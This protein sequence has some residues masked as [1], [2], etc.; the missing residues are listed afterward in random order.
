MSAIPIDLHIELSS[1]KDFIN[2]QIYSGNPYS[3]DGKELYE[4]LKRV[5]IDSELKPFLTSPK[6]ESEVNYYEKYRRQSQEKFDKFIPD[7]F[8]HEGEF[9][10]L[11]RIQYVYKEFTR[12]RDFEKL[13]LIKLLELKTNEYPI[14]EFLYFQQADNFYGQKESID[15]FLYQL[16]EKDSNC[17]LLQ[18]TCQVLI[19]WIG[20]QHLA[21]LKESAIENDNSE[22]DDNIENNNPGPD[23]TS[24]EKI[25]TQE[26]WNNEIESLRGKKIKCKWSTE[27]IT[28]YF[29]FLYKEKSENGEPYLKKEQ[30]EKMFENGFCIPEKPIEPLFQLNCSK[31]YPVKNITFS[32]NQFYTK[33][34][35][36][37]SDKRDY[38]QFFS[39]FIEGYSR[40]MN[41][42]KEYINFSR[43]TS[44]RL[45]SRTNI[46][47]TQYLP[48][49]RE[50]PK[51]RV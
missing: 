21:I 18:E 23:D 25:D 48:A 27:Q 32:I 41:S 39:M 29:S 46:N 37:F 45:P 10:D 16:T 50:T 51:P 8:E 13:F 15:S 2:G 49:E 9:Y 24:I 47:W 31:R 36:N 38:Y 6:D 35:K 22:P 12:P 33:S 17:R 1:L 19:D 20:S 7:F 26:Q 42:P 11:E 34:Y 5:V 40:F 14:G 3:F 44:K 30:V 4:M 43:N 28:H